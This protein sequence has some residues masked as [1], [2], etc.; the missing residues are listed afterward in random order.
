[1]TKK[2]TP[3]PYVTVDVVSHLAVDHL[4]GYLNETD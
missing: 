2:Y 3:L 1:M 4:T